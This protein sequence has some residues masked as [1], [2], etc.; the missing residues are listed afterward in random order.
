MRD[1]FKAERL[2]FEKWLPTQFPAGKTLLDMDESFE[3]K[4]QLVNTLF[5]GFVAGFEFCNFK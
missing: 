2:V 5:I 1:K 3:Y 4:E